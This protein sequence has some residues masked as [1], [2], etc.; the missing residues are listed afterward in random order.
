MSQAS[1]SDVDQDNLKF[2]QQGLTHM[3]SIALPSM[4]AVMLC[5]GFVIIR[6]FFNICK[7]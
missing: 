1:K 5:F 3:M 6:H 2:L 4:V 7:K